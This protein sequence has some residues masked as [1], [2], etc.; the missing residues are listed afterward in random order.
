MI[1][2]A[3]V[4]NIRFTFTVAKI[5]KVI[6]VNSELEDGRHILMWDFDDVDFWEVR[7]ALAQVLRKYEL[8]TI[9]ILRTKKPN[10]YHAYCFTALNWRESV[11]IV[12]QTWNTDWQFIRFGVYRGH[13]TLRVTPKGDRQPEIVDRI[14]GITKATCTPPDL[15]S[16]VRYETLNW[17]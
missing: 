10:N 6:G 16:W 1:L 13:W 5:A 8:S 11:E 17:R 15:K 9:H 3:T 12:T 4:K 7:Y 2:R 14:E